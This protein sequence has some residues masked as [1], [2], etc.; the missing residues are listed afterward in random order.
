MRTNQHRAT[1]RVLSIL[2][3][4]SEE[5]N[6]FSL[7][8][9][10][11]ILNAPKSSLF[12]IIHTL[13][14]EKFISFNKDTSKYTMGLN[15]Y[16][17]G[18]SYIHTHE[19]LELILKEMHLIVDQCSEICQLGILDNNKTLYIAKVDSPEAIRLVSDVNKKLPAYSTALGKALLCEKSLDELKYIFP[20][21]LK[22]ITKYT[23]TNLDKLYEEI[24]KTKESS[25]AYDIEETNLNISCIA[26]PLKKFG[27][28]VAAIS[29]STPNFRY[30]EEK[31]EH[32]EKLLLKAKISLEKILEQ[33][34]FFY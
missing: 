15:T 14:E 10:S 13:L 11:Q 28:I 30:T 8:E 7:T 33:H 34:E 16:L 1:L 31:K 26:V 18:N 12:P 21:E 20:T 22:K 24:L 27:K 29:V 6:G 2:K 3:S 25:L 23:I 4:L 5:T 9:L 19:I 32:I 17:L